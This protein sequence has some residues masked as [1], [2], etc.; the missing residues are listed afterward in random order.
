MV[1]VIVI[2]MAMVIIVVV[3]AVREAARCAGGF[4]FDG[5]DDVASAGCDGRGELIGFVLEGTELIYAGDEVAT[6][7]RV[8]RSLEGSLERT[9]VL[10]GDG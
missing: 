3:M 10:A 7:E 6:L 2:T 4:A 5:V 8:I 1:I 9:L